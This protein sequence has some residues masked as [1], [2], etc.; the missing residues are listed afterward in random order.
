[1]EQDA[2][3]SAGFYNFLGWLEANK[4]RVAMIAAG[5]AVVAMIVAI[6]IW[7]KG[8]SEIEAAEA[9]SSVRMP[10]SPM[11]APAPGTAEAFLKITQE[12]PKTKASGEAMLRA[13]SVYFDQGN[14]QQAQETFD[15]F[16]RSYGE[17]PYVPQAVF[18][19]ASCLDAQ[20]K[21]AEA[22]AKYNDF[23]KSYP[24]DPA[25]EQAR[26]N[27]AR[28]HDAA[29]QPAQAVE[30][31][32]KIASGGQFTPAANEAQERLKVLYA[33]HPNLAPPP[34]APPAPPVSTTITTNIIMA[35]NPPS[36]PT[37]NVPQIILQTPGQTN[38]K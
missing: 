30:M 2:P 8:Q 27:L 1:M 18:G 22:I 26:L 10:F 16:I 17:T 29:N 33:K 25:A 4:Q 13:A 36:N 35:T 23:L 3:P 7:R 21:T 9:M 6:I 28:L 5:V 31:L 34:P 37:S 24:N 32:T 15:K 14:Y 38:A 20:N 11:E 12:Y 19:I